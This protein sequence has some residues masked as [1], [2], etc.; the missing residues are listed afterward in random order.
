EGA[1][2]ALHEN[3]PSGLAAN[4]MPTYNRLSAASVLTKLQLTDLGGAVLFSTPHLL[5]GKTKIPLVLVALHEGKVKQGIERDDDGELVAL[6]VFP[7]YLRGK[8]VGAGVFARSLQDALHD[9]K[10]KRHAEAFIL[11]QGGGAEYTTDAQLLNHLKPDLPEPGT[12]SF[13]IYQLHNKVYSVLSTPIYDAS[14]QV[15]AQLVS[16]DDQTESYTKQRRINRIAYVSVPF[17]VV[18]ALVGL[19]WYARRTFAPLKGAISVMN[20]IAEVSGRITHPAT[21]AGQES[22]SQGDVGLQALANHKA[23]REIADLITAFQ[24]MIEKRRRVEEENENLLKQAQ[25]ANRAKSAFLANMSHEIRTPMNGVIGM[26]GLLLDTE[27]TQEQREYGEAVR[28]SGEALLAII[29]DILDFSKI[30]AGKL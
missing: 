5:T 22:L 1:L 21:R 24:R 3:D 25:A 19:Y 26:I 28:H 14:A 10:R 11:H 30:E 23:S 4:A 16:I 13:N 18:S 17:V 12:Q 29:N 7:L 6:L 27:L 20:A 8:P 2:R 9:F 15:Q